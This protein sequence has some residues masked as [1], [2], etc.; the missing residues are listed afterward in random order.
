MLA[1]IKADIFLHPINNLPAL[2]RSYNIELSLKN[3]SG[4]IILLD[5]EPGF[6]THY[7]LKI[8]EPSFFDI[9]SKNEIEPM[10]ND[11]LL[12]FN[13]DMS[14]TCISRR[15]SKIP[16]PSF[17]SLPKP[18]SE[19]KV[20]KTNHGVNVI[21]S[22]SINLSASVYIRIAY[23]E[24]ADEQIILQ[25]FNQIIKLQKVDKQS[26]KREISLKKA[27]MAYKNAMESFDD[28]VSYNRLYSSIGFA[29]DW[30]GRDFQGDALDNEIVTLTGISKSDAEKWRRFYN[31]T[32]HVD[33]SPKH[34]EEY[35]DGI[36]EVSTMRFNLRQVCKQ[37]ITTRLK[38][39]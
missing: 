12:A 38:Q 15:E 11:L 36:Q 10:L 19:V 25:Y 18:S 6:L 29:I 28:I 16:K 30:D 14:K 22:D 32:K 37:V 2:D 8:A 31:R 23:K 20:E 27:L 17:T 9:T 13:L 5:K 34:I 26:T 7:T 3:A 4:K 39:I 33:K 35:F 21:L 1:D 24:E